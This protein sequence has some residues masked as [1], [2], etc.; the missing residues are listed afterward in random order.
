MHDPNVTAPVDPSDNRPQYE[1]PS[2]RVMNE[3]DILNTF[4]IT[5]SMGTWWT[6]F[7]SPSCGP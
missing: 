7:N 3:Q 4:Q 5:Q 6:H 1:S 2:I